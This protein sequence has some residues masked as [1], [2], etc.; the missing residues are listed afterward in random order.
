MAKGKLKYYVV[1]AGREPGVYASWDECRQQTVG[2]GGAKYK[3][4]ATREEAEREFTLGPEAE[5]SEEVKAYAARTAPKPQLPAGVD[6]NA[7]AVDAACSG[8]PGMME[9][10]GVYLRTGRVVFKYGPTWGTNNIGEFLAIVHAL[11]LLKQ[12]KLSMPVYSD[13]RNAILWVKLGRCRTKLERSERTAGI[14]DMIARAE[15]WL[16]DND[17]TDTPIR[18]WDTRA[19]GEIPADFGRKH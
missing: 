6:D 14:Y 5:R 15:K 9:Y 12:R 18:K 2:F 16:R 17:H 13:S 19:W 10:R 7:L 3:S 4:F 11:A 8:N 1:W